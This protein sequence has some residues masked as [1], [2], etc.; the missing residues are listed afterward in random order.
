MNN[1]V[2]SRV[3]QAAIDRAMILIEQWRIVLR[4]MRHRNMTAIEAIAQLNLNKEQNMM[5]CRLLFT[6]IWWI[7]APP[8]SMNNEISDMLTDDFPDDAYIPLL[9]H[10]ADWSREVT[11]GRQISVLTGMQQALFAM[12][13]GVDNPEDPYR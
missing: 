13:E 6:Y 7:N 8:V 4:N 5:L 9:N 3:T 1:G 12:I 10:V 2:P 11:R